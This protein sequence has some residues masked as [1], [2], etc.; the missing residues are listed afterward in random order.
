LRADKSRNKKQNTAGVST[1]QYPLTKN[2]MD[3]T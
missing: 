2:F 3:K 1:K